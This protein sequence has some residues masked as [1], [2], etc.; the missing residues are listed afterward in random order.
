LVIEE[1]KTPS[2]TKDEEEVVLLDKAGDEEGQVS[3]MK[4]LA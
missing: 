1:T 4:M 2:D 3:S